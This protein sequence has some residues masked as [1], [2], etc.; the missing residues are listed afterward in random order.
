MPKFVCLFL[1]FALLGACQDPSAD[2][3]SDLSQTTPSLQ[4][5]YVRLPRALISPNFVKYTGFIRDSKYDNYYGFGYLPKNYYE[6]LP[7]AYRRNTTIVDTATS[8]S[9]FDPK[10]LVMR[11]MR[12]KANSL[13]ALKEGYHDYDALTN[14]VKTVT[15]KYSQ[16]AQLSS[17]GRSV[18]GRE[19]WMVKISDNAAKEE[20]EPKLLYIANMHG[21]EVVGREMMLYLIRTLTS[22]YG[23]NQ[24]VTDLVNNSQIYIMPSMNPDGFEKGS[25]FNAK[26][27]DLNRNFPDFSSDPNDSPSG[28]Q[29]ETQAIM[30]SISTAELSV[31]IYHGTL[32]QM[33]TRP[34]DLE[35]TH[36]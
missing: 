22:Q 19:L 7:D 18:Q 15:Q 23:V 14:E 13:Y 10:T 1:L 29:V 12:Y 21:D 20:Y 27:S 34:L 5:V 6:K 9:D 31:L 30:R 2:L 4:R 28:R 11:E 25:R 26:G 16:I 32:S 33:A 8:L 17:A 36:F 24:R 3:Q 35:T